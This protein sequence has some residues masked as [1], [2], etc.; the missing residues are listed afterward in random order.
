M[1]T[2]DQF[3]LRG[4][5][6]I[7]SG[8]SSGIGRQC[9][10]ECS[11]KEAQV[12]LLGRNQD[13]LKETAELMENS[14]I[15]K[16]ICLDLTD[17]NTTSETISAVIKETGRIHGL[18]NS[19]GISGTFPAKYVTPEKMDE[20][21]RVNVY[22]AFN[23]TRTVIRQEF[24]SMEGGSIIFISSVMGS[25]GESGKSL[26]SFTKGALSGGTK[27]LAVELAPR[28][29]RVNCISP[30]VV[31]TPMSQ[32]A[33]YSKDQESLTRI[34]ALHPLGTGDP[35]DVANACIFL[36]SDASKWI[37]GINLFVDGGYTAR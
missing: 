1:N 23:L 15:H 20:Y 26:Y 31:D 29:I 35:E 27:S 33:V 22:A 14:E 25:V 32:S 30:G 17:F 16:K 18:I 24:F 2:T 28:K 5:T 7:I 8:A 3:A 36:L 11:R 34:K 12:I 21:F 19:A 10:I 4:K 13:R 9:A 6:V 37:T